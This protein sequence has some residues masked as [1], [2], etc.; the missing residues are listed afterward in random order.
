MDPARPS[1]GAL[2]AMAKTQLGLYLYRPV[3][4][5]CASIRRRVGLLVRSSLTNGAVL[6]RYLKGH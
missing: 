6:L 4:V 5:L 1:D 2:L 3:S